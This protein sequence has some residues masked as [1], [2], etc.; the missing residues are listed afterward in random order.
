MIVYMSCNLCNVKESRQDLKCR[1]SI[2]VVDR[3]YSLFEYCELFLWKH[4]Q[5]EEY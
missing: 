2:H 1:S 5:K 3:I 4:H